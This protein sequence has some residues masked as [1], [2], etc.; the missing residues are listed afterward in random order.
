M[1]K[2][3][4]ETQLKCNLTLSDEMAWHFASER[5]RIGLVR[6]TIKNRLGASFLDKYSMNSLDYPFWSPMV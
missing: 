1:E 3:I 6:K 4:L 5:N 2:I